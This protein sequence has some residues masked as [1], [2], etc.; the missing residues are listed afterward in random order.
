MISWAVT[1]LGGLALGLTSY[2]HGRA[3]GAGTT[4]AAALVA[5]VVLVVLTAAGVWMGRSR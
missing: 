4:G 1:I 2:W 5:L 3:G